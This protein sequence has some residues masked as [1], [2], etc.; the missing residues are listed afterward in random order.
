MSNMSLK[1]FPVFIPTDCEANVRK[2]SIKSETRNHLFMYFLG[3]APIYVV[4]ISNIN[5]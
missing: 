4:L 5:I 1:T 2:A 3:P